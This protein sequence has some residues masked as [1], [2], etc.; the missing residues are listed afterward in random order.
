MSNISPAVAAA[1]AKMQE[2]Q[3]KVAAKEAARTEAAAKKAALVPKR[4]RSEAPIIREYV[5]Q[6]PR[7]EYEALVLPISRVTCKACGSV[8]EVNGGKL[9]LARRDKLTGALWE[10]THGA[11]CD[12]PPLPRRRRVHE[13][14]CEACNHC[15]NGL[16]NLKHVEC[17][18]PF[19]PPPV[20]I[21]DTPSAY[22]AAQ[23]IAAMR[24]PK[25]YE[26]PTIDSKLERDMS[27]EDL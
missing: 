18:I 15:F 20:P 10:S 14:T 13:T 21:H 19:T 8:T 1:L 25:P 17:L 27:L 24:K 4:K 23:Q 7:W 16:T 12:L 2:A 11:T 26:T 3:K 5:P 6:S 9:L 22:A